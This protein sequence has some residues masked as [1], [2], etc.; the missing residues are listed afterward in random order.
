MF[1]GIVE[2]IGTLRAIRMGSAAA[3]VEIAARQ[4]LEGT[5]VGDSILTDGICLTVTALGV[6]SF[7]ADMMPETL[8]RTAL[9]AKRPGSPVNLERALTPQSRLG[10]HMVQGHVDGVATVS[11]VTPES[12]AIVVTLVAPDEVTRV[13]VDQGSLA[14]DGVSL[15]IVSVRGAEL[16]VSLIPHTAQITTLGGLRPGAR[17]NLEAD[18]IGK[19]VY[20]FLER[21]QGGGEGLSWEKLSE[22]GFV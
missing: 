15:T 17:V 7:A 14:L 18:L 4:V 19:Y 1:T 5:R 13:S 8:R 9:A 10:G 22:A 16:R 2:E 12:N 20:T 3:T 11:A 21:R 6:G